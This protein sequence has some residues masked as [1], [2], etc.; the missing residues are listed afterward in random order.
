VLFNEGFS[1]KEI[2]ELND[3]SEVTVKKYL[4][5]NPDFDPK[6]KRTLDK[7]NKFYELSKEG[8]SYQDIAELYGLSEG[9]VRKY[10][11]E[12]P[13][14]NTHSAPVALQR[15][16]KR[17]E[18]SNEFL[19]LYKQGLTYQDIG[20][21]YELTRERV[22]QLLNINPAFHKYLEEYEESKTLAEQEKEA[23]AKRKLYESSLSTLY[24]KQTAEFWDYEKNGEL[25]PDQVLAGSTLVQIWL[26]CPIDGASWKKKPND[27][28]I[29]WDRGGRGCPT[30][31]GKSKKPEKQPSLL[32]SYP[33]FVN[34]YWD[35]KKNDVL[36][37]NPGSIS[38]ASNRK[39][40]FKCPY[41][42]HEWEARIHSA[43]NQQWS[44]GNA[45]CRVCNGTD[46][47][48]IGEWT[49][50]DP[51]T[52]EFPD[53]LEKYWVYEKNNQ[54]K[55]YPNKVTAGSSRKAWLK[56]P[57]DGYEWLSPITSTINYINYKELEGRQKW[58]YP[59]W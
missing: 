10:L 32:E 42:S 9:T 1:Y 40:W 12:H 48:K 31:A 19:E 51:L 59:L 41:D 14:F 8:F 47:R 21:K 50:R 17:L 23:K 25:K 29:S 11:H 37:L 16:Q 7:C 26:K 4:N 38:L 28:T 27:I 43:V 45:G 15:Q 18:K 46:K 30:C 49:R 36:G 55:L 56:C 52:V 35:Y 39:V 2:A 33:D 34:Q 3:V 5:E 54:I 24:P 53:E 22:R 13:D 57:V 20:N 44:K 58:L 6:L